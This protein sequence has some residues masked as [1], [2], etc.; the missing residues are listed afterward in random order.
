[1]FDVAGA[2]VYVPY[3][4]SQVDAS[5]TKLDN[6]YRHGCHFLGASKKY[7]HLKAAGFPQTQ[8]AFSLSAVTFYGVPFG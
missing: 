8:A 4:A 2:L 6:T 1:M 3:I 5:T 7:R